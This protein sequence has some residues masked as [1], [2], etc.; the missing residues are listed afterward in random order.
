VGVAQI[1]EK[2]QLHRIVSKFGVPGVL[3]KAIK[4]YKF[5][6]DR[7]A[8]LGGQAGLFNKILLFISSSN[9]HTKNC[10]PNFIFSSGVSGPKG[11]F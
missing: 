2:F 11:T 1:N 3:M 6:L 5:Q 10:F 7:D 4:S 8:A 9:F